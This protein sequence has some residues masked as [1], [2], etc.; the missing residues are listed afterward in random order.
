MP[1]VVDFSQIHFEMTLFSLFT[2]IAGVSLLLI[3]TLPASSPFYS[4]VFFVS[5]EVLVWLTG[6]RK[7]IGDN[8]TDAQLKEYIESTLKAGKVSFFLWFLYP[9]RKKKCSAF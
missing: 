7:S 4:L 6:L 1:P 2:A 9:Q 8:P 3:P 5:Q